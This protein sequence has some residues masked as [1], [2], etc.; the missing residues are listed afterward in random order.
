MEVVRFWRDNKRRLNPNSFGYRPKPPSSEEPDQS[1]TITS[2]SYS[3]SH[4][5]I[6]QREVRPY[7]QLLKPGFIYSIPN[8]ENNDS[9]RVAV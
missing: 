6:S 2:A 5:S 8:P 9:T 1:A 7:S 4:E 3:G